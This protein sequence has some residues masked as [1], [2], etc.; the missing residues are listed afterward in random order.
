MTYPLDDLIAYAE[1]IDTA[2]Y[3]EDSVEVFENALAK[4]NSTLDRSQLGEDENLDYTADDI[5]SL[6]DELQALYV[7][8]ISHS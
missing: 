5:A 3:T 7:K 6:V 4:A 2:S 8:A 1:T